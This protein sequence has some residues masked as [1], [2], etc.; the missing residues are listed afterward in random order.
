MSTGMTTCPF[1]LTLAYSIPMVGIYNRSYT[2]STKY[3]FRLEVE[4]VSRRNPNSIEQRSPNA[5]RDLNPPCASPCSRH[6]PRRRSSGLCPS[7]L[8]LLA[9][10][11]QAQRPAPLICGRFHRAC[12]WSG[13]RP[14]CTGGECHRRYRGT[15]PHTPRKS[16]ESTLA[17]RSSRRSFS[18]RCPPADN[19]SSKW[20]CP[21]H[22]TVRCSDEPRNI[23]A[24]SSPR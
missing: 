13:C 21:C 14:A 17:R 16:A 24:A 5:D 6:G 23:R 7:D 18:F 12:C 1:A 2:N 4:L 9:A 22:E 8:S 10:H 15:P 3:Y 19:P 11:R 20:E